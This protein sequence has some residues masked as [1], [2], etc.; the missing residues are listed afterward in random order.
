[1][2]DVGV[3]GHDEALLW[4][5]S[6]DGD[7]QAF[8]AVFDLHRHRVYA[9]AVRLTEVRQDAEDIAAA[10]FL[11]LWRRRGDVRLVGGSVL[12]W[13][14]VTT[15]HLAR[16]SSRARRR[17]RAFLAR[18]PREAVAPDT[19]D[20]VLTAAGLGIDLPMRAALR[21]LSEQDLQLFTLVALEDCTLAQAAE[22][23]GIGVGAAKTRLHRA[24]Q[25]LRG[26][27]PDAQPVQDLIA[28]S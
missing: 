12:A 23:L 8:A 21:S 3:P 16:N 26:Q 22:A 9:H 27:L 19:A 15:T 28:G 25:Q 7:S 13:L 20:V 14:L 11:E 24:R 1:L 18:L 5:R 2:H 6:L 10:A 17:Y 4:Q